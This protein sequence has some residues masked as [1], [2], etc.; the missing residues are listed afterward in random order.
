MCR[1]WGTRG[2][3]GCGNVEYP[4]LTISLTSSTISEKSDWQRVSDGKRAHSDLSTQQHSWNQIKSALITPREATMIF[5]SAFITRR[6]C[7]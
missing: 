3:W 5:G 1:T 2:T 4:V 6:D 7:G